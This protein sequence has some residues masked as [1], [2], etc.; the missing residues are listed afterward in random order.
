MASPHWNPLARKVAVELGTNARDGGREQDGWT[1]RSPRKDQLAALGS[2]RHHLSVSQTSSERDAGQALECTRTDEDWHLGE[3]SASP[4][5]AGVDDPHVDDDDDDESTPVPGDGRSG[6][7]GSALTSVRVDKWLWA[8]RLYKSRS[9]AGQ[10]C[11]AGHVKIDGNSVKASRGVKRGEHVHALTPGG[12]RQVEVID[13]AEKRGSAPM[14]AK[15][16]IDHTPPPPPRDPFVERRD[17]GM[18]RPSKRDRR[19]IDAM[20]GKS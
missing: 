4:S 16:Y 10:A 18:G 19:L 13:L 9:L 7:P 8:A 14:A 15:L 20:R 11:D 5:D 6:S 2:T 1:E 3:S 17:R 12:P